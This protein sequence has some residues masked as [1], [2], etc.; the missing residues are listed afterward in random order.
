ME[1]TV[2]TQQSEVCK[3]VQEDKSAA[4]IPYLMQTLQLGGVIAPFILTPIARQ[5]C[6]TLSFYAQCQSF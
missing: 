1:N 6:I 4:G 5:Q 2:K 3:L